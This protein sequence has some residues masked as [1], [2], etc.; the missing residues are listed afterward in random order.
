M[1]TFEDAREFAKKTHGDQK[2]GDKP[3]LYHLDGVAGNV[4]SMFADRVTPEEYQILLQAAYLHDVLEDTDTTTND[5]FE[6]GFSSKVVSVVLEM[7]RFP[8]E[9]YSDYLW[10]VKQSPLTLK[11]KLADIMFNLKHSVAEGNA[12]RI[13][14]YTTALRFLTD[15]VDITDDKMAQ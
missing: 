14:K 13:L 15:C 7:T 12:K 1:K 4:A 2:Y 6:A 9:S 3:Y 11:L 10:S 8:N 5:L